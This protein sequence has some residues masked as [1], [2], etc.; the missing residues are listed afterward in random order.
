MGCVCSQPILEDVTIIGHIK[1]QRYLVQRKHLSYQTK[2]QGM[3]YTDGTE[4]AHEAV[5]RGSDKRA[6]SKRCKHSFPVSAVRNIQIM[7]GPQSMT[8]QRPNGIPMIFGSAEPTSAL[9]IITMEVKGASTT[10]YAIV[11]SADI[12]NFPQT[13]ANI[14][15][16]T[17]VSS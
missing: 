11:N 4:I 10:V 7:N 8:I 13:I 2:R 14:S 5:W 17:V 6:C 15:N 3:L 12:G 1:V 9:L 16:A